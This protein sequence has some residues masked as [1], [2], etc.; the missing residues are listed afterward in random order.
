MSKFDVEAIEKA[1]IAK[2]PQEGPAFLR[3]VAS[4]AEVLCGAFSNA[5]KKRRENGSSKDLRR[6]AWA[7]L[8]AMSYIIR[9]IEAG[10][11]N[12][13]LVASFMD[14]SRQIVRNEGIERIKFDV[15][16]EKTKKP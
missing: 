1:L 10:S 9:T 13:D 2:F 14:L 6:D 15:A 3:T 11:P 5:R 16:A 12:N 7:E 4:R 8:L